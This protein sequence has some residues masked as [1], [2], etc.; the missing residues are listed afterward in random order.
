MRLILIDNINK[1][2]RNFFPLALN[3][4][5]W[6][7]RCGITTLQ[8]KLVGKLNPSDVAYFVPDYMADA[9]RATVKNPV[10]VAEVLMVKQSCMLLLNDI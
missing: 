9:Y 7:L 3:R 8:E 1:C 2:R 4:P 5:L 6:E 10:N